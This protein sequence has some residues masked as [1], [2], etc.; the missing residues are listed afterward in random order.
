MRRRGGIAAAALALAG[1]GACAMYHPAPLPTHPDL[2]ARVADL[3]TDIAK[4]RLE[5]LRAIHIDPAAGFTPLDVAV[6]AALDSPE[7]KAKRASL[8]VSAAQ[9]FAA[10]LLPDPQLTA[11]V[12]QPIAGPD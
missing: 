3:K 11:G 9:V 4:L 12:D 1:L 2:G 5:P 10:G 8:G 7:L 6:L